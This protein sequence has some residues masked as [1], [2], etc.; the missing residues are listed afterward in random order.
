MPNEGVVTPRWPG[1]PTRCALPTAKM[2]L[3]GGTGSGAGGGGGGVVVG[4]GAG[5]VAR[6]SSWRRR[7]TPC[8]QNRNRMLAQMSPG[9]PWARFV[10]GIITWSD[11]RLSW[12]PSTCPGRHI[13]S[14]QRRS[15]FDSPAVYKT[16]ARALRGAVPCRRGSRGPVLPTRSAPRSGGACGP[17]PRRQPVGPCGPVKWPRSISRGSAGR[18]GGGADEQ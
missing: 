16:A 5:E 4:A 10:S 7:D 12:L 18:F 6:H 11:F 2:I 17:G 3:D 9:S 14:G 8:E 13:F 15:V 1:A